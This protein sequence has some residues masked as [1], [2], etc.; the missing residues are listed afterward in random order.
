[1]A[2][3]QQADRGSWPERAL[4]LAGLG[5]ACGFLFHQLVTGVRPGMWTDQPL[6]MAAAVFV[7]VAGILFAFA[8]E[9]QRWSW[10][11]L[12][13]CAGGLTVAL[14]SAWNG[15]PAG[16]GADEG[17]QLFASL[18][19]VAV[20]VPLFQTARDAGNLRFETGAVH[21][22]V[23]TN[24]ILW[25]AACAFTGA[26]MLLTLLLAELFN[27]IGIGL[28]R[29]LLEE[30]WFPATVAGTAFGGAVALLRDRD[31]VLGTIQKVARAI[32]SVLAPV[33][34]AGLLLFVL[35]LPFTGLEPLWSKTR[36]T[37]PLL[38]LC[39]LASVV[40]VNASAGNNE[41]EEARAPLL[42]WSGIGLIAVML[43]LAAVAAMSLGKRI[44]QYGYTPER[45]WAAVFVLVAASAGLGYLLSL[46]RGRGAWPA[47]LRRTNVRLAAGTCLLAL[48]LAAPILSFGSLSARDQLERLR[49][50]R[51]PPERFD[52]AAMRF[53]FGPQ[54]REALK[55]L[56]AAGPA[57]LRA[58]AVQWLK[59][60]HR[61]DMMES[62]A[63]GGRS[64]PVAAPQ[65][66]VEPA[67]AP[68]PEPLRRRIGQHGF[69]GVT[70]CRLVRHGAST[71]IL[72]VASCE[73]C[74]PHVRIYRQD[75]EGG[76]TD[77]PPPPPRIDVVPPAAPAGAGAPRGRVEVRTIE[78]QQL[79]LDGEPVGPLFD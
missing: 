49:D 27:L 8:L 13:A 4:L 21:G 16:W 78:K 39:I 64:G 63:A 29:R 75:A 47:A 26:S 1:M 37:T 48:F 67:A 52:W 76:W 31:S 19:A 40:L 77:E 30:G 61:Y 6:R 20:A 74:Q 25:A 70:P 28:L 38:L 42:R 46:I 44:G 72:L 23:W 24:L 3:R 51:T 62:T 12:F 36:S 17:W 53:D 22:H 10:S 50:G 9:R 5:A 57:P 54:G 2:D 69:C 45:L 58:R 18:I 43:P 66:I 65:L 32:L 79:F 35:A 59:A 11:I 71:A 41:E 7:A 56:A 73:G 14:V 34:S 33:L 60:E 15:T 55:E 68:V